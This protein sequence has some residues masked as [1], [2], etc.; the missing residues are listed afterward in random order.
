[1]T[2]KTADYSSWT[3]QDWKHL[4]LD[5]MLYAERFNYSEAEAKK[6]GLRIGPGYE[7]KHMM[8]VCGCCGARRYSSLVNKSE[9][10]CNLVIGENIP[11]NTLLEKSGMTPDGKVQL[12][13]YSFTDEE[14]GAVY[15]VAWRD[16]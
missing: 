13:T 6:N 1:M 10:R 4:Y 11:V 14:D 2:G 12:G 8:G 3:V 5:G 16:K 7:H 9:Y 15:S